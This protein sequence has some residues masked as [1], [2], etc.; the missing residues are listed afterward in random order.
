MVGVKLVEGSALGALD[1][2]ADGAGDALG[3]A[4]GAADGVAVGSMLGDALGVR[5]T[6]SASERKTKHGVP[7]E[8]PLLPLPFPLSEVHS[9]APST[10]DAAEAKNHSGQVQMSIVCSKV[11]SSVSPGA[12]TV[13][14]RS[15]ELSKGGHAELG[16]PG[17]GIEMKRS[18]YWSRAIEPSEVHTVSSFLPFLPLPSP[19]FLPLP[20]LAVGAAV[21]EGSRDG[22]DEI[23]GAAEAMFSRVTVYVIVAEQ[24]S[25]L[26]ISQGTGT[27]STIASHSSVICCKFGQKVIEVKKI[28]EK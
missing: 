26:N 25:S 17:A 27:P 7:S 13:P 19:S 12:S 22:A 21:I 16:T 3:A 5:A 10:A 1:G 8:P 24:T 18:A 6:D 23:E 9:V 20:F 14:L 2:T 28:K 4:E 11:I 15:M